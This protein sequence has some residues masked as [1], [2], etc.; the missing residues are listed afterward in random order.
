MDALD[1]LKKWR[2]LCNDRPGDECGKECPLH[3]DYCPMDGLSGDSDK[4]LN[5]IVE[6]VANTEVKGEG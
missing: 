4:N 5:D 3:Y 2:D 6:Y 1:F